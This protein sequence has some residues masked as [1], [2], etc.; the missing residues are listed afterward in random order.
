MRFKWLGQILRTGPHSYQF[1]ALKVQMQMDN[2][3]NIMMDAPPHDNIEDLISLASNKTAWKA[4]PRKWLSITA[5]DCESRLRMRLRRDGERP[6][7]NVLLRD[8]LGHVFEEGV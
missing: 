5:V 7:T 3:G 8:G 6:A 1:Q 4:K 2:P